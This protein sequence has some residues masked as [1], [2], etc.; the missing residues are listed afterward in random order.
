LNINRLS[1]NCIGNILTHSNYKIPDENNELFNSIYELLKE[2]A[3]LQSLED[4]NNVR[5]LAAIL[6]VMNSLF[7]DMKALPQTVNE[8][9][10]SQLIKYLYLGTHFFQLPKSSFYNQNESSDSG[11]PTSSSDLSDVEE[12]GDK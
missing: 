5:L 1:L 4:N 3:P 7:V 8:F 12:S 11:F 9:L 2:L 6:R 10:I